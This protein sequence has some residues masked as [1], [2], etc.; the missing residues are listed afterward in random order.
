MGIFSQLVLNIG[1]KSRAGS[2]IVIFLK[3]WNAYCMKQSH[4]REL[5]EI[6]HAQYFPVSN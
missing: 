2:Q 4:S 5:G 1:F 3:Q 6:K